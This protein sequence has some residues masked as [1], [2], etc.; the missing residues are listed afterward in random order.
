[1]ANS[2]KTESGSDPL[3]PVVFPLHQTSPSQLPML[4]LRFKFPCKFPFSEKSSLILPG[5]FLPVLLDFIALNKAQTYLVLDTQLQRPASSGIS[6][7][8]GKPTSS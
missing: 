6:L 5:Q 4:Y 7:A 8:T 2:G 1:M 3:N